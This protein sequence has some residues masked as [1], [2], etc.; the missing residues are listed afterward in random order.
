M[1]PLNFV[2]KLIFVVITF[3]LG[4]LNCYSQRTNPEKMQNY[5]TPFEKNN[6]YSAS[7][8]ECMDWYRQISDNHQIIQIK[9][10]GPT[11][12]GRPLH[13][14]II[15]KHQDF[16]VEK[17]KD[18]QKTV[19]LINNAIHPGEPCGVD[20][21]MMLTRDLASGKYEVI[22]EH[23]VVLIIPFYNIGGALN[24]GAHSRTN[25]N[26]PV[27]HGFR[28]NAK[29]LDLNRDFIKCDSKNA[30]S[31]NKLYS[32]W[33][34]DLFIDTHTSN[35]ADY[36]YNMSLIS[37]L[38]SKLQPPLDTFMHDA[39][40]PFLYS[41]MKDAGHEMTPYVQTRTT[42]N[43]GISAFLD[44]PRYSSGYAALH[45]CIS[46]TSE[47]HMLKPF[48]DRVWATYHL[49]HALFE[50]AGKN[51]KEIIKSRQIARLNCM[52]T[53]SLALRWQLNKEISSELNFKG[54]EAKYKPSEV[55]GMDRLYYDKSEPWEKIIPYY[56]HYDVTV[57]TD[58]PSVYIIPQAWGEVLERLRWNG[59]QMER[60]KMDKAFEVEV[61]YIGEFETT[62]KPYEGHYPHF[63]IKLDKSL[64][65]IHFHKGDYMISTRQNAKRYIVETLEP[66]G[67]DGFFAWNFFDG[68]LS[69]KEY[70]SSYVFEDLAAEYL[71]KDPDLKEAFEQRKIEDPEFAKSAREQLKFI[72]ERSPHFEK[73]L[74]RY[75]V[76]RYYGELPQ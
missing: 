48:K 23:S 18:R 76:F 70:F 39:V 59:V 31:F 41:K 54:Y 56:H 16:E 11:D 64:E 53:D 4:A 34:P 63:N 21:S 69:Q 49:L 46:F 65:T 10:A 15:D 40:L 66:L 1:K 33:D 28:G 75:P 73:T 42:P 47:A 12:S 5:I 7:Y 13:L 72:Y 67:A 61:Y 17:I 50:F 43:A 55:T 58:V 38:E 29:N 14:I 45:H 71:R 44:L 74:N 6:N 60:L 22:L 57:K 30:A 8:D 35:G 36:Q 51:Y 26:G 24:R 3:V 37:T 2:F 27:L 62:Q 52:G 32:L 68:V 19:L 20:A 9:E 25:Q